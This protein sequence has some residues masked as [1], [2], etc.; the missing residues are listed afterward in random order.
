MIRQVAAKIANALL[1]AAAVMIVVALI[2]FLLSRYLGDP[3]ASLAGPE[4]SVAD[5]QLLRHELGL[6]DPLPIQFG[7]F[8]AGAVQGRFGVSYRFH[9]PAAELIAERLPAT[10]ELVAVALTLAIGMGG[11]LG[12]Y[13]AVQADAAARR[14]QAE[15]PDPTLRRTA[16]VAGVSAVLA[17][18]LAVGAMAWHSLGLSLGAAACIGVVALCIAYAQRRLA[19]G[20]I[21][22]RSFIAGSLGRLGTTAVT[23]ATLMGVSLP[24]F[25]VGIVLIY[26]FSVSLRMLPAFGRGEVVDVGGW[27]SGLFTASG[28]SSIIMPALTL[29]AYQFASVAR[30]TRAEMER[31]LRQDYVKFARARGL[32]ESAIVFHEALPNSI[33]PVATVI[34]LQLGNLIAFAVVTETVFQW[35]GVGLLFIQAVQTADVPLMSA[36]L[37]TASLGFVTINI[38]VDV[39]HFALD[40][41][42]RAQM[43][44]SGS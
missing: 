43:E 36:Y 6:D 5:R 42:L 24:T 7:R 40:P 17:T 16:V 15:E 35:P 27:S 2:A 32:T 13:S 31:S 33:L 21:S 29:G 19:G 3:V 22:G 23:V 14:D 1:Q 12:V 4:A 11:P 9:R 20:P 26:I 30:L 38:L 39:L 10:L 8:V 18:G 34:G 25:V 41:R 44:R 37:V 28:W